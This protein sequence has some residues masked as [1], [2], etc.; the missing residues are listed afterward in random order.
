MNDRKRELLAEKLMD[1]GNYGVSIL[2]FSQFV[3]EKTDW[4]V[5]FFAIL[6]WVLCFVVNGILD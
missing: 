3:A 1:M 4:N 5:V 2:A 6:F